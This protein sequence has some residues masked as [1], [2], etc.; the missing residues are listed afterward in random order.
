MLESRL[1]ARRAASERIR[2][3]G[4]IVPGPTAQQ[5][6]LE[7][8]RCLLCDDAPCSRA[9]PVGL[10]I[11]GL[12]RRTK[13]KDF[14]SAARLLR[15]FCVLPGTC[16]RVCPVENLCVGA[17]L[18]KALSSPIAINAI[19]RFVADVAY[20]RLEPVVKAAPN[21]KKV[22]VI[23]SGPAGLGA[24]YDLA[25]KG[26]EVVVFEQ[27]PMPGGIAAYGI[28]PYRLPKDVLKREIAQVEAL[29]VTIK[30]QSPISAKT[31]VS[32]LF[33]EGFDAV[34]V[35]AGLWEST[36]MGIP[37][38]DLNGV[39][40][41]L[42]FLSAINETLGFQVKDKGLP[43]LKGRVFVIGGGN[44]A[45]DCASS[46]K[47]LGAE[48]VTVV[49]RR[50]EAE[51]P[52]WREE[53]E[54]AR[55]EGVKFMFLT[56]PVRII[57]DSDRNVTALECKKYRLGDP[58]ES[59]RPR[60]IPI[61]GS[62]FVLKADYVIMGVGQSPAADVAGIVSGLALSPDGLIP[63]DPDTGRTQMEGVFAG[64]DIVNGGRTVVEALASGRAAASAIDRY[65]SSR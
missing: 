4:E 6:V 22:A 56:A 8:G 2:D 59:G 52:A 24:A 37:G 51:M 16:G 9:C 14:L 57:G 63:V 18:S 39:Y 27:K 47:R 46:A 65:L 40:R 58:D 12:M 48:E 21:G 61:D 29:G 17:C 35:A 41:A 36:P 44:V 60:P 34:F 38:E 31:G 45:M 10:D 26:Y 15:Q 11:P 5:V 33:E 30:T 13:S 55:E 62:E 7:A 20:D 64:G 50:T 3:F 53:I 1:V 23:G 43:T 25:L 42:D 28:P 32:G 19:Q 54:V 49:Y